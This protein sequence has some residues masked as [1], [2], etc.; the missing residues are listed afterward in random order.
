VNLFD[1]D[2]AAKGELV[3]I[4]SLAQSISSEFSKRSRRN[5]A[6]ELQPLLSGNSVLQNSEVEEWRYQWKVSKA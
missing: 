6:N 2:F 5:Q 1:V 4:I 3:H